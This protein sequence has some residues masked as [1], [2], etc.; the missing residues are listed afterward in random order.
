MCLR[1][2][3]RGVLFAGEWRNGEPVDGMEFDASGNLVYKGLFYNGQ[4][5]PS[6]TAVQPV[7]GACATGGMMAV[8]MLLGAVAIHRRRQRDLRARIAHA[9]R[10]E[11]EARQR[12]IYEH[13]LEQRARLNPVKPHDLP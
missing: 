3:L 9:S 1:N 8:G 6:S 10:T 13:A 4:R 7:G 11:R 12:A 5:A 2:S